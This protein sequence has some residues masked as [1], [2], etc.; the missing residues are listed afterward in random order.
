MFRMGS[1]LIFAWFVRTL[2]SMAVAMSMNSSP[3][4]CRCDMLS[5]ALDW[6]LQIPGI[7]GLGWRITMNWW[8]TTSIFPTL[9]YQNLRP[10]LTDFWHDMDRVWA[11]RFQCLKKALDEGWYRYPDILWHLQL[12]KILLTSGSHDKLYP[13]EHVDSL[14]KKQLCCARSSLRHHPLLT[15]N[16]PLTLTSVGSHKP[17]GWVYAS[18][19]VCGAL[20][21]FWFPWGFPAA[22]NLWASDCSQ[23]EAIDFFLL[24]CVFGIAYSLAVFSWENHSFLYE[25][26]SFMQHESKLVSTPAI[27][28]NLGISDLLNFLRHRKV[29][30]LSKL[31]KDVGRESFVFD[32]VAKRR[33][34]PR[35]GS[36]LGSANLDLNEGLS[37]ND[38]SLKLLRLCN[39]HSILG[40]HSFL[41]ATISTFFLGLHPRQ[42][43]P[44][45]SCVRDA[46]TGSSSPRSAYQTT[47]LHGV[48]N[49]Y[50]MVSVWTCTILLLQCLTCFTNRNWGGVSV[51]S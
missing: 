13:L 15:W 33:N 45:R 38:P 8:E 32:L 6:H 31:R 5:E 41:N 14:V 43:L 35:R 9:A 51:A 46:F 50:R 12:R 19:R 42:S 48:C 39:Q 37:S 10:C 29:I 7:C 34:L 4:A 25:R 23:Y 36:A 27:Q 49:G 18:R 47:T 28:L 24:K 2:E 3:R 30:R 21:F 1:N 26:L 11:L 20:Y 17:F 44:P 40:L 16:V 22:E